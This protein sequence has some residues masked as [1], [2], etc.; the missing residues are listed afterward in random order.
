MLYLLQIFLVFLNFPKLFLHIIRHYYLIIKK[1]KVLFSSTFFSSLKNLSYSLIKLSSTT[2]V[3]PH[4]FKYSFK[5]S[6]VK[7]FSFL[8]IDLTFHSILLFKALCVIFE[9]PI[10]ILYSASF[11]K[12]YAFV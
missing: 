7:L 2:E 3:S 8:E 5:T 10:I 11:S 6:F 9:D 4:N 12:I 1:F